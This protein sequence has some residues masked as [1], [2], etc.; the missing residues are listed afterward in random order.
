MCGE[1]NAQGLVFFFSRAL[2]CL[3]V[4]VMPSNLSK[5]SALSKIEGHCMGKYFHYLVFK[6]MLRR[7]LKVK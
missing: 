3:S 5:S 4:I 6:G 2:R 7:V 1:P